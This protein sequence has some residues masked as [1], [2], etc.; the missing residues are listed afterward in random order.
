MKTAVS[1][2]GIRTHITFRAVLTVRRSECSVVSVGSL[3]PMCYIALYHYASILCWRF[4]TPTLC[5]GYSLS[6]SS[7]L[8]VV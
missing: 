6:L 1:H 2:C 4:M 7:Q 3:T 8:N 5:V